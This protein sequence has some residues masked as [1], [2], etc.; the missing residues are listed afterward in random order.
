GLTVYRV[1]QQT[2]V[3]V[4]QAVRDVLPEIEINLPP[5]VSI[6]IADDD[7]VNYYNQM[8]ILLKNA[9]LGLVLVLV[10][11]SIFLEYRLAFWV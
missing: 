4:S 7:S 10:M 11:L 1:G 8:S 5:Y 2:P 6:V 3:G 9:F